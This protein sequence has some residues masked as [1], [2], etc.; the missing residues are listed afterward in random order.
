M[1]NEIQTTDDLI[2]ALPVPI[3]PHQPVM[4]VPRETPLAADDFARI[5]RV[6]AKH[7]HIAP[8]MISQSVPVRDD[9]GHVY[10]WESQLVEAGH[11]ITVRGEV[12]PRLFDAVKRPS[13]PGHVAAHLT[14][15]AAH[16][17]HTK[18]DSAWQIVIEDV[19]RGLI[20]VS[21]WAVMK[22]CAEFRA[23]NCPFFP[24][25]PELLRVIRKWNDLAQHMGAT[26]DEVTPKEKRIAAWHKPTTNERKSVAKILHDGGFHSVRSDCVEFCED[27][28]R[29]LETENQGG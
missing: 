4:L 1:A 20:G 27:C 3:E 15:L 8:R 19:A 23:G 18:G 25:T 7:I 13:T 22:A 16:L 24:D 2:K 26:K 29:E 28:R 17:R 10:R 21:E 6:I 12:D 9:L 14:R 5:E 11:E